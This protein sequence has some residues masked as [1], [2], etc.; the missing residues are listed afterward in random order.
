MMRSLKVIIG[1]EKPKGR[2][3]K[4]ERNMTNDG[5]EREREL[6]AVR[7]AGEQTGIQ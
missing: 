4:R 1:V 6:L 3:D 5:P 2:R 7:L